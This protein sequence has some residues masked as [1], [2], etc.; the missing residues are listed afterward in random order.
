M[1]FGG[2]DG[3]VPVSQRLRYFDAVVSS[4]ACFGGGHRTMYQ[5]HIQILDIHFRKFCRSIAGPPPHIDRTLGMN[6][7]GILLA[8]PNLIGPEFVGVRI[9]NWQLTL[10]SVPRITGYKKNYSGNPSDKGGLCGQSKV[11]VA[12]WSE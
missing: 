8:S 3:T 11:G 9:G 10:P 4:F 12:N 1:D 5:K 7:P 6:E 2:P